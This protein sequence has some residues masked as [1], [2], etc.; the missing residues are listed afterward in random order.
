LIGV[1]PD[2]RIGQVQWFNQSASPEVIVVAHPSA[3]AEAISVHREQQ[4]VEVVIGS[5]ARGNALGTNDWVALERVFR[6]LAHD[7]A[8][9]DVRAVLVRGAGSTFSSGSD[10]QE[11]VAAA[12]DDVETSFARM[13]AALT[14]IEACPIPVIAAVDGVAAGAGCQLA[15]ACDLQ[16]LAGHAR[17]GM[18]IARLGILLSPRFASRLSVLAGPSVTRDLLYTGRLLD[19]DEAVR[20]GLATRCVP[21][22]DFE[23]AIRELIASI[24]RYPPAAHH[25]TKRAVSIALGP[26]RDAA[27][28]AYAGNAVEFADFQ[29]G[30]SAFLDGGNAIPAR[31]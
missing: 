4:V 18:P 2:T 15:L 10:L 8:T 31:S 23:D 19:A 6:S 24:V 12:P 28:A 22:E 3:A 11:W 29:A 7:P 20:V 13:E 25:A 17:I 5:G 9:A 26:I 1:V 30:V 16:I 27:S 21:A 14:A